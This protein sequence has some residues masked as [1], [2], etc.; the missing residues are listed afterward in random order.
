MPRTYTASIKG[1]D[2]KPLACAVVAEH[3]HELDITHSFRCSTIGAHEAK[4]F[5]N[6]ALARFQTPKTYGRKAL[7]TMHWEQDD[8]RAK[9]DSRKIAKLMRDVFGF[10]VRQFKIRNSNAAAR[11]KGAISSFIGDF[12]EED[13]S[14]QQ[15]LLIFHFAGHGLRRKDHTL[16]IAGTRDVKVSLPFVPMRTA[17][18]DC[19]ADVLIILDCCHAAAGVRDGID[20]TV[21]I[22]G[23]AG[24]GEPTYDGEE[25][26]THFFDLAARSLAAHGPFTVE[27]LIR[28]LDTV[29]YSAIRNARN[30]SMKSDVKPIKNEFGRPYHTAAFHR[31]CLGTKPIKLEPHNTESSKEITYT[32]TP[33]GL[34]GEA[35][36]AVLI[37]LS[38]DPSSSEIEDFSKDIESLCVRP[39]YTAKVILRLKSSSTLMLVALPS[40]IWECFAAH[41]SFLYVGNISLDDPKLGMSANDSTSD[42][43]SFKLAKPLSSQNVTNA[44]P[45][46]LAS[47]PGP[48]ISPDSHHMEVPSGELTKKHAKKAAIGKSKGSEESEFT[49]DIPSKP[50]G[51]EQMDLYKSFICIDH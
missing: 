34:V 28:N 51:W 1:E 45:P 7:L 32:T 35:F 13:D 10:S 14:K 38:E 39:G 3:N 48:D 49:D 15:T 20:R 30:F 40:P 29:H 50:D 24:E 23:A 17:M 43:K 37:H 8:V 31:R 47:P 18:L 2:S 21:E 5:L 27:S 33:D 12:D 46:G 4:Q 16:H 9:A 41:P 42:L 11:V 36:I 25:S 26:F 22:I 44:S 6:D 19:K